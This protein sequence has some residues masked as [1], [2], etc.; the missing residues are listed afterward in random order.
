MGKSFACAA[1]EVKAFRDWD[2]PRPVPGRAGPQTRVPSPGSVPGPSYQL[3]LINSTSEN[4]KEVPPPVPTQAG[5][6]AS[7]AGR[8]PGKRQSLTPCVL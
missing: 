1:T 5:W 8:E 2:T 3:P 4:A 7:V 6:G